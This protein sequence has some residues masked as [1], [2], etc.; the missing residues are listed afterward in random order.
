MHERNNEMQTLLRPSLHGGQGERSPCSRVEA[1]GL[2]APRARR[3]AFP[4][5]P[6][7]ACHMLM[8]SCKRI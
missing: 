7:V 2:P 8:S 4:A 5:D 1:N 6:P 3:R